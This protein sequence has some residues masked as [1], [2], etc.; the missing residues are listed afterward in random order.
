MI[1]FTYNVEFEDQ[2]EYL[3]KFYDKKEIKEKQ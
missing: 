1:E 2:N 3:Q